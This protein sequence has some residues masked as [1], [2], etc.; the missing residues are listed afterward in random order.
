MATA[1]SGQPCEPLRSIILVGNTESTEGIRRRPGEPTDNLRK[2]GYVGQASRLP[3]RSR[4]SR[5]Y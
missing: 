1:L 3:K 2:P 5:H 4:K